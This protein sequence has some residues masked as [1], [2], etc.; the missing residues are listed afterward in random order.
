ME[1]KNVLDL[2]NDEQIL[3]SNKIDILSKKDTNKI[4]IIFGLILLFIITNIIIYGFLEKV[5]VPVANKNL[6][7]RTEITSEMIEMKN[8]PRYKLLN[9][10]IVFNKN[11]IIGKYV[12]VNQVINANDYFYK[13]LLINKDEIPDSSFVEIEDGYVLYSLRIDLDTY[14]NN[15]VK[16]NDSI[17]LYFEYTQNNDKK[18]GKIISNVKVADI[19]TSDGLS[20]FEP[21]DEKRVPTYILISMSENDNQLLRQLEYEYKLHIFYSNKNIET[22]ITKN[23]LDEYVKD[24]Y[25]TSE[26]YLSLNIIGNVIDGKKIKSINYKP[27][28]ITVT[29]DA[30]VLDSFLYYPVDV[31]VDGLSKDI[32]LDIEIPKLDGVISL[33]NNL[34]SVEILLEDE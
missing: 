3:L 13:D 11:N 31:N 6:Y 4:F 9:E 24:K 16:Q 21:T 7:S 18:I 27:E 8:L 12:N 30:Q 28:K 17:N 5:K 25:S 10:N 26:I 22:N 1:E 20:I 32:V 34:I 14:M 33:N 29:G 15:P 2:I 23:E 19:R